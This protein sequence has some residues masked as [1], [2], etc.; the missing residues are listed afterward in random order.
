[1]RWKLIITLMSLLLTSTCAGAQSANVL[2]RQLRNFDEVLKQYDNLAQ[3]ARSARR[4]DEA[5]QLERN[6][7]AIIQLSTEADDAVATAASRIKSEPGFLANPDEQELEG[8]LRDF[9]CLHLEEIANEGKLPSANDYEIFL[10]DEWVAQIV[11][12]WELKNKVKS[13]LVFC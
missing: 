10:R 7:E 12:A 4:W 6:K 13:V 8:F 3:R 11:P 1:M 9:L 5:A 2:A